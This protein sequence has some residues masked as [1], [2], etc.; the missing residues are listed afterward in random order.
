MEVI[1]HTLGLLLQGHVGRVAHRIER[2]W[3]IG[4]QRCQQR[5][6]IHGGGFTLGHQFEGLERCI[7]RGE[8]VHQHQPVLV[9]RP[10]APTTNRFMR[11]PLP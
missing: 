6:D 11:Q 1:T 8:A 7:G 2:P 4:G 9:C 3:N 10:V 5:V